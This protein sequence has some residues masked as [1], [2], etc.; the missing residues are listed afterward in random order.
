MRPQVDR[1]EDCFLTQLVA[2]SHL[3]VGFSGGADSTALL[4]YL[5]QQREAL[6]LSVEAVHLNHGLRGAESDGD[7][8][9]VEEFCRQRQIPLTV[10][11]ADIAEEQRR[12]RQSLETCGREARYQ[13]F[14]EVADAWTGDERPIKIVTAHTLSDDVETILFHLARGTALDGLCGI[15]RQ[16]GRIVR[17]LLGCTREQVEE[18]CS[19]H[20]LSFVTDSSNSDP[21]YRRNY[22]RTNLV[23]AFQQLNPAFLEGMLRMREALEQD[24]SCLDQLADQWLLNCR[25]ENG[26]ELAPLEMLPEA[27]RRRIALSLLEEWKMPRDYR[28]VRTLSTLMKKGQ[29]RAELRPGCMAVVRRGILMVERPVQVDVAPVLVNPSDVSDG[30]LHPVEVEQ[31]VFLDNLTRRQEKRLW[32]QVITSKDWENT[33]KIY[34]NLL[35]FAVDYDT[36]IGSFQIRARQAGDQLA[37]AGRSGSKTLKKLFSESGLSFLQRQTRLVAADALSVFWAEGFGVDRRTVIQPGRTNRIL[38]GW[39]VDPTRVQ[40]HQKGGNQDDS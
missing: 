21:A 38:L 7:E 27:L 9:F 13:L 35:F 19:R 8:A 24:R 23:P 3:V 2:G 33:K 17:P 15:P 12:Q 28:L 20:G 4:H 14:E 1:L 6:F 22:I 34:E 5:W 10:R 39:S 31:M 37:V 36:I 30:L 18:Y 29:G 11:R 26:L 25:R 32:L 40:F 16:R